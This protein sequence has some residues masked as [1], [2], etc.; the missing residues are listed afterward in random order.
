MKRHNAL[1]VLICLLLPFAVIALSSAPALAQQGGNNNNQSG[2]NNSQSSHTKHSVVPEL[3]PG[4]AVT[5]IALLAIGMLI[6]ID[7]RRLVQ[8]SAPD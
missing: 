2:G 8:P 3:N 1:M 4:V 7:R 6:L 5:G